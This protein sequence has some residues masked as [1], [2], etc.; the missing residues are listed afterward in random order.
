MPAHCPQRRSCHGA[1]FRTI[2]A[3]IRNGNFLQ[4]RSY[5]LLFTYTILYFIHQQTLLCLF[6]PAGFR[7]FILINPLTNHRMKVTKER[8]S[9]L[10]QAQYVQ[11]LAEP[12][13]RKGKLPLWKIH[14]K[15]VIEEAP[16]SL[17]TFRKM[18]KEDVSHLN[19]KIE[20][21]RKQMEELQFPPAFG[22][23]CTAGTGVHEQLRPPHHP[24]LCGS[25][26]RHL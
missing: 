23:A 13:I 19:E 14:T 15:F 2:R 18:L 16:V 8:L 20:I 7:N 24:H 9:Y 10:K 3:A 1:P 12:Y 6:R 26:C 25:V 21:Y 4:T 22:G 17:N 5:N 11:R